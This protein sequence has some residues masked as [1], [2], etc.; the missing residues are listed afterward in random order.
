MVSFIFGSKTFQLGVK[1]SV[2]GKGDHEDVE[3]VGWNVV[4]GWFLLVLDEVF[5]S[6][7]VLGTLDLDREDA[8]GIMAENYA[9]ELEWERHATSGVGTA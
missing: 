8:T 3:G 4:K 2:H 6:A 7:D 5:E 9:I 1:A